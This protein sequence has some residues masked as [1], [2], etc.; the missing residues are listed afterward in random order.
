RRP[1]GCARDIRSGRP[2]GRRL[3]RARRH[4]LRDP[5][6]GADRRR[7]R[8]L[9]RRRQHGPAPSDRAGAPASAGPGGGRGAGASPWLGRGLRRRAEGPGATAE[10]GTA[11]TGYLA[12][13]IH[14]VEPRSYAR[15]KEM[16]A[17][18]TEHGVE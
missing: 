3:R 14:D 11:V 8:Y 6:G 5:V 10:G 4:R 7:G 13:A 18:L 1:P 12:V 15:V 16:R 17:W 9:P 2:G